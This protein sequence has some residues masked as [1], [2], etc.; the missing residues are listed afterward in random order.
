MAAQ[1]AKA[2]KVLFEKRVSFIRTM[3]Q[4]KQRHLNG[5]RL[6]KIN[7]ELI[8]AHLSYVNTEFRS[9]SLRCSV[10]QKIVCNSKTHFYYFRGLEIFLVSVFIIVCLGSFFPSVVL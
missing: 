9:A 1:S 6:D 2:S 5:V 10:L 4:I 7:V 3:L 8:F